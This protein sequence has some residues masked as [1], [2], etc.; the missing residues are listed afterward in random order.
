MYYKYNLQKVKCV[1]INNNKVYKKPRVVFPAVEAGMGH[2]MPMKAVSDTFSKKY[3]K[4]CDVITTNFYKDSKNTQMIEFEKFMIREVLRHNKIKFYGNFVIKSFQFFGMKISDIFIMRVISKKSYHPSIEYMDSLKADIVFSTH[5]AT[6][7]IAE[8]CN[9]RPMSISYCPDAKMGAWLTDKSDLMLVGTELGKKHAIEELKLSEDRV[10]RVPFVLRQEILNC[11]SR[12]ECRESLGF[13]FDEFIIVLADGGYGAGKLE[14]VVKELFK[15]AA[16]FT[17]VA[18]CGKN[19]EL[20]NKYKNFKSPQNIRFMPIG[21]CDYMPQLLKS[22]DIFAGKAGASTMAEPCY[23]GVPIVITMY[24]TPIERWNGSYYKDEV[25]CAI[26]ALNP[27]TAAKVILDLKNN[28]EKHKTLV[29]NALKANKNFGTEFT[30]DIIW[31][32]LC[33]KYDHL[34]NIKV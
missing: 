23:Y 21:F 9:T 8:H 12:D 29:N 19:E 15:S 16:T 10:L 17:I 2:I 34:K 28:K 3:G 33:K 1:D 6:A 26:E 13:K 30:A 24:A 31:D 27:K 7:Y 32:N 14:K 20:Y 11:K 25:G 18:V 22:A 5:W 4:Y